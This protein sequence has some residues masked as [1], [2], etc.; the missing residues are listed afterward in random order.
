MHLTL[1][2][3]WPSTCVWN[4]GFVCDLKLLEKV[5]RRWTKR[6][7]S[8]EELSYLQRLTALDLYSVQGRL[9]RA[10]IIK[11]WKIF[12][13]ECSVSP[14]DIFVLADGRSTRGHRY[15]VAHVHSSLECRR[16]S[17]ALRV[18]QTWNSL[19]DSVVALESLDS[20]KAALHSILGERLFEFP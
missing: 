9:L 13:Q 17:F 19:P 18:V 20:F 12:H 15:K 16:R 10:D 11:C 1:E 3:T 5:Q 7:D 2:V 14:S 6:I 8:F 4:T